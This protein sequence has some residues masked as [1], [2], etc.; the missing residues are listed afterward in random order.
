MS[1]RIFYL[2]V[3]LTSAPCFSVPVLSD[4]DRLPTFCLFALPASVLSFISILQVAFQSIR[5]S[6]SIS[7]SVCLAFRVLPV[8]PS[9][10]H[11][12]HSPDLNISTL[13]LDL[14]NHSNLTLLHCPLKAYFCPCLLQQSSSLHFTCH[15]THLPVKAPSL[16][17]ASL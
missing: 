12:I 9:Q 14:P 7:C 13:H 8:C 15:I 16:S 6:P 17:S 1:Y 3:E 10:S 4:C 11:S 5:I 2:T